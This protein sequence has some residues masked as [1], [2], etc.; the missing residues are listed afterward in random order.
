MHI[1]GQS[2]DYLEWSANFDLSKYQ[3]EI[4]RLLVE[5]NNI[6]KLHSEL[7]NNIEKM[8]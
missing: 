6:R 2:G 1:L 7:V 8:Q 4:S 3:E 5:S